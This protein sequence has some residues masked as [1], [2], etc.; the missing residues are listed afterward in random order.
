MAN[1]FPEDFRVD[2]MAAMGEDE[3]DSSADIA[4]GRSWRFDYT[5]GEFVVTPTG[6]IAE[7]EGQ[8]AWVEWCRKAIQTA[9]YRYLIYSRSYGHDLELLIGKGRDKQ[10][11]ESDME[12]MVTEALSIDPRTAA[13][14]PFAFEWGEDYCSFSCKITSTRNEEEVLEGRVSL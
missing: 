9:R 4:F 6:K 14:G 5:S 8:E 2:G 3:P 1:L 12:R 10:M 11:Q 13:V 7:A